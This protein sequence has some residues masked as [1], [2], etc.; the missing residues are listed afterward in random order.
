MYC[1]H[2]LFS[3][4]H[5]R[6]VLVCCRSDHSDSAVFNPFRAA[7]N[8]GAGSEDFPTS[9]KGQIWIQNTQSLLCI[10]LDDKCYCNSYAYVRYVPCKIFIVYHFADLLKHHLIFN[11]CQQYVRCIIRNSSC[12]N[13]FRIFIHRMPYFRLRVILIKND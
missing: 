13:G 12:N 11:R 9:H 5:K 8:Q 1:N 10:C 3:V 6:P 7:E 2:E 4:W